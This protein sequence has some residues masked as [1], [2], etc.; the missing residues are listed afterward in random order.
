MEEF[1]N[2]ALFY[3]QAY[4]TNRHENEALFLRLGLSTVHT[5]PSRKRSFWKTRA[6]WRNLKTPTL[7]FSV[8]VKKLNTELVK[9]NCITI[10]TSFSSREYYSITIS[11]WPVIVVFLNS[12][13]AVCLDGKHLMRFFLAKPSF[14]NSFGVV[15]TRPKLGDSSNSG[16]KPLTRNLADFPHILFC[17]LHVALCREH[18]IMN[19]FRWHPF[20][21]QFSGLWRMVHFT[22][23]YV[24]R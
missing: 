14:S 15:W 7:H 23:V 4:H 10:V 22:S 1:E 17:S 9:T 12:S 5:N 6:N 11:K 13:S 3:R 24:T 20:D 18:L 21:W 16:L 19:G 8:D 2:A